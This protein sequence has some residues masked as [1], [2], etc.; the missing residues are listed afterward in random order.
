[1]S[2]CVYSCERGLVTVCSGGP[3]KQYLGLDAVEASEPEDLSAAQLSL[4][5]VDLLLILCQLLTFLLPGLQAQPRL[6]QAWQPLG[7]HRGD[8]LEAK[9]G[10]LHC[11]E[12]KKTLVWRYTEQL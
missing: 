12:D 2:L 11:P 4:S 1:M 3:V 6:L 5:A 10:T 9:P 7:R 8:H